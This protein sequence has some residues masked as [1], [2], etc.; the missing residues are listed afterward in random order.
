MKKIIALLA[1]MLTAPAMAM[2]ANMDVSNGV[3]S[4]LY[5]IAINK[6]LHGPIGFVAGTGAIRSQIMLAI[7]A[8][9]GGAFM[10]KADDIVASLGAL[11]F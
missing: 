9:L 4:D 1:F 6:I 5:D 11:I 7:T 2:A 8:I 10:L 3:A